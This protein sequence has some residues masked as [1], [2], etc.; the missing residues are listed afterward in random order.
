M[1]KI[2]NMK[3]VVLTSDKEEKDRIQE[4]FADN[5]INYKIKIKE[6]YQKNI[7]DQ[8]KLGSL[9]N[10]KIKYIYSFYVNIECVDEA[11]YLVKNM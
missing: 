10:D 2:F 1:I 4:L 8:A 7:F 3:K 9:G 5:E 11:T 6:V